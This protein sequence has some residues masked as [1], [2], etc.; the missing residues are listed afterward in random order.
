MNAPREYLSVLSQAGRHLS[1]LVKVYVRDER[2]DQKAANYHHDINPPVAISNQWR[3]LTLPPIIVR[4][5][6]PLSPSLEGFKVIEHH[7]F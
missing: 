7:M 5:I 1:S 2:G 4:V 3:S 6:D